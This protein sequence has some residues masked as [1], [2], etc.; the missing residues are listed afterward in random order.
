MTNIILLEL[1]NTMASATP[2]APDVPAAKAAFVKWMK[3]QTGCAAISAYFLLYMQPVALEPLACLCLLAASAITAA[4]GHHTARCGDDALSTMYQLYALCCTVLIF[5]LTYAVMMPCFKAFVDHR[6]RRRV[7]ARRA[8]PRAPPPRADNGGW[9][10]S[11]NYVMATFVCVVY[12]M[13][14][15]KATTAVNSYGEAVHPL[16]DPAKAKAKA[17]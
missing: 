13:V 14:S 5:V 10:L 9:V 8:R 15:V 12:G 4:A 1:P 16:L 7:P 17:A 3:V 2:P 6:P 11:D